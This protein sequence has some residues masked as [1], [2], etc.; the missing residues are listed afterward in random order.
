LQERRKKPRVDLHS[1]AKLSDPGKTEHFYGHVENLSESGFGLI[2]PDVIPLG[3]QIICNF[4]M[5]GVSKKLNPLATLVYARQDLDN[6]Y[7]YGFRFDKLSDEDRRLIKEYVI[8][9]KE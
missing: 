2:S 1:V 4:F 6:N 3:V 7:R 9:N 5:E 8:L